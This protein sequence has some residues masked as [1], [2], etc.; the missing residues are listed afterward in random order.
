MGR[1]D[2]PACATGY[3]AWKILVQTGWR[4]RCPSCNTRLRFAADKRGMFGSLIAGLTFGCIIGA[5]GPKSLWSWKVMPAF[6]VFAYLYGRILMTFFGT[7]EAGVPRWPWGLCPN[8]P[9][10]FRLFSFVGLSGMIIAVV[11]GL[12]WR[13]L[14]GRPTA[15][16]VLV[17]FI[18]WLSLVIGLLGSL[19]A[20]GGLLRKERQATE[21]P[22]WES[23][24]LPKRRISLSEVVIVTL[25]VTSLVTLGL[26]LKVRMWDLSWLRDDLEIQ[27]SSKG[28]YW[29]E[30]D[31]REGKLRILRLVPFGPGK[32]GPTGEREGPFEVWTWTYVEGIPGSKETEQLV[33]SHYNDRMRSLYRNPAPFFKGLMN[34]PLRL[35]SDAN[36]R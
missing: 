11:V 13:A 3:P 23:V 10:V 33:V 17:L 25:C 27:A 18:S 26:F 22:L 19:F 31:F 28:A 16:L 4:M 2:C 6:L 7:I 9:P 34:H 8:Q 1:L 30:H 32:P 14:P 35:S 15:M 29:A 5:V 36:D 24:R 21:G 12:L 20:K